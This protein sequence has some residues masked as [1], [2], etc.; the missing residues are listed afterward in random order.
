MLW[1]LLTPISEQSQSGGH[2]EPVE[3]IFELA[4]LG[5]SSD[6]EWKSS[7]L[8]YAHTAVKIYKRLLN[9]SDEEFWG[10]AKVERSRLLDA[11]KGIASEPAD[12]NLGPLHLR[13]VS[14]NEAILSSTSHQRVGEALERLRHDI[15]QLNH[16][17]SIFESLNRR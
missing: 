6:L 17:L 5:C 4:A 16:I 8:G 15:H 14:V 13:I 11:L 2:P 7:L 9:A 12:S 1:G 3:R 10:V